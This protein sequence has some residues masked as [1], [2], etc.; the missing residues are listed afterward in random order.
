MRSHEDGSHLSSALETIHDALVRAKPHGLTYKV[1]QYTKS[2]TTKVAT[3]L[4]K[5]LKAIHDALVRAHDELQVVDPAE[6][7]HAVGPKCHEARPPRRR[8]HALH[9]NAQRINDV[10][11]S[12]CTRPVTYCCRAFLFKAVTARGCGNGSMP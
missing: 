5:A 1:C 9:A 12:C 10:Q 8:P 3:H 11:L 4:R 7:L 2:A 6:V